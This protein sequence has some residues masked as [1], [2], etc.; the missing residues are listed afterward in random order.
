[1]RVARLP[2]L[3]VVLAACFS[4]PVSA[5]SNSNTNSAARS[6]YLNAPIS[7]EANR[8]QADLAVAFVSHGAGYSLLLSRQQVTLSLNQTNDAPST[9]RTSFLRANAN[10]ELVGEQKLQ[11]ISNYLIGADRSRWLTNIPNFARVRYRALYPGIDVVYYGSQSHLEYDFQLAPHAN[12]ADIRFAVLGATPKVSANGDLILASRAQVKNVA[13]DAG[14]AWRKPIAYQVI[15]GER[16]EVPC[17]YVISGNTV[18]FAVAAYDHENPLT[19]DPPLVWGSFLGGTSYETVSGVQVDP[20]G[21]LVVAGQTNSTNFPTTAGAYGRHLKG[22]TIENAFVSK[23]SADGTSLIYSTYVGGPSS[24]NTVG[25]AVDAQGN[26]YVSGSS[27]TIDFPFTPGSYRSPLYNGFLFKLDATGTSLIYSMQSLAN[28][29]VAV[30]SSGNAY[31]AGLWLVGSATYPFTPDAYQNQLL[32]GKYYVSVAKYNSAGTALDYAAMIGSAGTQYVTGIAVD[33]LG[34]ASIT[35]IN[36]TLNYP[37]PGYPVTP[38]EPTGNGDDAFVTKFNASGTALVYSALLNGSEGFGISADAAGDVAV[39]GDASPALPTTPNAY[40][41]GFQSSGTGVH[42]PFLTRFDPTGHIT[43]STFFAGNAPDG[44][45]EYGFGA[46]IEPGGV[47]NV[48]GSKHSPTFPITDPT[49]LTTDC[50]WLA[51]FDPT[52]SGKSSLLYSG[53]LST[54]INPKQPIVWEYV[55]APADGQV[56]VGAQDTG[57]TQLASFQPYSN[58]GK[59]GQNFGVEVWVG[60]LNFTNPPV[61]QPVI[62]NSPSNGDVTTLPLHYVATA[63]TTCSKGVAAIGVYTAPGVLA[64]SQPGP[65]LDTTL[66]LPAGK[67]DTIVQ[68]W[69]NCGGYAKTPISIDVPPGGISVASPKNKSTVTSPVQFTA[70]AS[71]PTCTNGFSGMVVYSAPGVTVASSYNNQL[72]ASVNLSAGTYNVVIQ[73][74][75]NCNNI[76]QKSLTITVK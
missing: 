17:S 24:V 22:S 46:A 49:Y 20:A 8:G 6:H 57:P 15:A 26:A 53:C 42:E 19:I 10:T 35:G 3:L 36:Y 72:S 12:A 27:Q 23:F 14:I 43:Y 76:F 68:E 2:L 34:E 44:T 11:G 29:P 58:F 59:A 56:Y 45:Y 64:Y 39:V 30:D 71:S 73:A 67:H 16:R 48:V 18:H 7:F 65:N 28:G 60:Y 70:V 38:G 50:G 31:V 5:E 69:D 32:T 21:E 55:A 41:P 61:P 66:T 40:E 75:D 37:P 74:F 33:G 62:V 54:N 47:I 63:T 4:I 51:R 52:T 13:D 25:L 1:M 9:I